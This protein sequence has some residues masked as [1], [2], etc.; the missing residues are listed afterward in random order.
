[1]TFDS[2]DLSYLLSSFLVI[3]ELS[4]AALRRDLGVRMSVGKLYCVSSRR[5]DYGEMDM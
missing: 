5:G 2:W 3:V 1:M 4:M